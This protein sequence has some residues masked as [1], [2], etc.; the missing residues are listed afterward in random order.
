[1]VVNNYFVLIIFFSVNNVRIVEVNL[2]FLKE[3]RCVLLFFRNI[4]KIFIFMLLI[5]LFF[6]Y[7]KKY[8]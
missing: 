3:E 7:V 5:E 2:I 4:F 1:M 8:K 6:L